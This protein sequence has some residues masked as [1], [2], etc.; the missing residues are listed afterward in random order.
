MN[1]GGGEADQAAVAV[2]FCRL[3]GCDLVLAEALADQIEPGG[4][5]GIAKGPA[6]LARVRGDDG[7]GQGFSGF[8]IS[9]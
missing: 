5:R 6:P 7:C 4:E 2:D 3:H 8:A 1:E 9:A